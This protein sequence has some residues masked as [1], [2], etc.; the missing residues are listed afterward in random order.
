MAK[1]KE[2]KS[3]DSVSRVN[4]KR[5]YYG[6]MVFFVL[7]VFI[8]TMMMSLYNVPFLVEILILAMAY[9]IVD[10]WKKFWMHHNES[11]R[12]KDE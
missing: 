8:I 2:T 6:Y 4:R 5:I 9:M 7:G 1:T 12:N 10:S 3:N 11:K